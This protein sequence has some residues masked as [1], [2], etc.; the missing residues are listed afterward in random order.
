MSEI[1]QFSA[2]AAAIH[3]ASLD[4]S[5]WSSVLERIC[6]FVPA[7]IG[8]I[9]L[10]EGAAKR[11]LISFNRDL[12]SAWK[13]LYSTKY[14]KINPM[15]PALLFCDVGEIFCSS[16]L[17]PAAQMTQTCFYRDYLKPQGLGEAVGAVLEKSAT[18]F[19]VFGV[20]LAGGLGR[21]EDNRVERVRLLVPHLRRAVLAGRAIDVP[22]M[23]AE[24]QKATL[25]PSTFPE[26]VAGQ[27]RLT[28]AELGVMFSV[29]E[30]GNV[31]EVGRILGLSPTTVEMHLLSILAKTG[32]RDQVGL[33]K[34]VAQ[35][36]N[37]ILH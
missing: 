14:F 25:S 5:L 17:I 7:A 10:Q 3:D 31:T 32:A 19:A 18:S 8:N 13:E 37:P 30:F 1:Q 26:S 27:F 29:I 35:L 23:T 36:A 33:A 2:L 15:F 9:F 21:V 20:V 34:L 4:E 24:I 6:A 22:R 16:D 12:E 11:A 28:P